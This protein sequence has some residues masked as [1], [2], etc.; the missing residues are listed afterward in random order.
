MLIDWQIL[1][2]CGPGTRAKST[3]VGVEECGQWH[4]DQRPSNPAERRTHDHGEDHREWVQLHAAAHDERL[5]QMS[6]DLHEH[7]DR[8]GDDGRSD[9]AVLE[10]RDRDDKDRLKRTDL[11][12]SPAS[13]EGNPLSAWRRF[14]GRAVSWL[15]PL[16]RA[17]SDD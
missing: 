15:L 17:D 1:R 8:A 11:R 9:E 3:N 12:D 16:F 5:Q 10:Q 14:L 4:R 6:F 2:A 7:D 13:P